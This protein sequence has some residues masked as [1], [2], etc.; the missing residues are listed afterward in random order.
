MP[1][2]KIVRVIR[3]NK[4]FILTSHKNLEGDA[5]GS[6]LALMF[7]LQRLK[8]KAVVVDEDPVPVNYRF[9]PGTDKIKRPLH[10]KQNF[11]VGVFLDCANSQRAGK[12]AELVKQSEITVNIDHHISNNHFGSVNWVSSRSSSAAEMV[13]YLYKKFFK[14]IDY[15]SA[16]CIYTGIAT[17][18]GFFSYSNASAS[19]YE[20]AADLVGCGVSPN[21]VYGEVYNAFA[22]RDIVSLT[23]VIS[24]AESYFKNRLIVAQCPLGLKI[25]S[26]DM[27]DFLLSVLRNSKEAEIFILLRPLDNGRVK[28]N[29]RSRKRVDVNKIASA[30]GGGGHKNSAGAVVNDSVLNVRKRLL[31]LFKKE[32]YRG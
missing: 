18:T 22:F 3:D 14:K 27:T 5:L 16:L 11:D 26:G 19:A 9:L 17:D 30:L 15:N 20:A 8:K 10:L 1:L 21:Y 6:E 29:F 7:L 31:D 12:A 24:R 23:K 2:E 4:S 25:E 13:Y 28:I 32:F